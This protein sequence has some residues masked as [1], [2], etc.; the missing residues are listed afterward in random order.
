M[1]TD[2]D[3]VRVPDV[4]GNSGGVSDMQGYVVAMLDCLSGSPAS[5]DAG[6][7]EDQESHRG[8]YSTQRKWPPKG[9]KDI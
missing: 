5:D 8:I 3:L 9:K 2:F 4:F 1:N 7:T 6:G